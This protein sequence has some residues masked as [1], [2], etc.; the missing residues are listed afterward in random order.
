MAKLL[1]SSASKAANLFISQSSLPRPLPHAPSRR[2]AAPRLPQC[3]SRQTRLFAAV[4]AAG[5][6]SS[7]TGAAD[8]IKLPHRSQ[9]F[10]GSIVSVILKLDQRSGQ[11]TL[12]VVDSIL[13]PGLHHDRGIKVR[14]LD[15]RVGR[16]QYLVGKYGGETV[17]PTTTT[18]T[19]KAPGTGTRS[20]DGPEDWTKQMPRD[21][22]RRGHAFRH[23][24]RTP[25][26]RTG[27]GMPVGGIRKAFETMKS[28]DDSDERRAK[29]EANLKDRRLEKAKAVDA[30]ASDKPAVAT[31]SSNEPPVPKPSPTSKTQPSAPRPKTE[32][33]PAKTELEEQTLWFETLRAQGLAELEK[34]DQSFESSRALR[35]ALADLGFNQHA[36]WGLQANTAKK[37]HQEQTPK[38]ARLRAKRLKR[39]RLLP[40]ER[41][42]ALRAALAD[43]GFNYPAAAQSQA[44]TTTREYNDNPATPGVEGKAAA[45][46]EG[47]LTLLRRQPWDGGHDASLL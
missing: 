33:N 6:T 17:G 34:E 2:P 29:T 25:G 21:T 45:K 36:A 39:Q 44:K 32:P 31:P 1:K 23:E 9:I 43:L 4:A 30:G 37:K 14:L 19:S 11:E 28:R 27:W 38:P 3:H 7:L 18:T 15:G 42:G 46:L 22:G 40:G 13:T 12:G 26:R 41:S 24:R 10:K 8:L 16:V 47:G 35:A 20:D 5:D